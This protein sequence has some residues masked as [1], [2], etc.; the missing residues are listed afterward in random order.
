VLVLVAG[1]AETV[2]ASVADGDNH[3]NLLVVDRIVFASQHLAV[4]D[5]SCAV[6]PS[7]FVLYVAVPEHVLEIL[8]RQGLH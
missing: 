3:S 1:L 8:A 2:D 5:T 7:C 6:V 4:D